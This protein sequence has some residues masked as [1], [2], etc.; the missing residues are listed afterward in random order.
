MVMLHY[1]MYYWFLTLSAVVN[2]RQW[3]PFCRL[4]ELP[5]FFIL[6]HFLFYGNYDFFTLKSYLGK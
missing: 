2:V 6:G 5:L 4:V 1:I 3:I